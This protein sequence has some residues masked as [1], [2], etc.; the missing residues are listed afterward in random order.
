MMLSGSVIVSAQKWPNIEGGGSISLV[1]N[2]REGCTRDE[3][4]NNIA[5]LPQ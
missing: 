2:K 1:E 5:I 4:I 3:V